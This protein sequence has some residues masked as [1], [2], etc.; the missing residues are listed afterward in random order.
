MNECVA[1]VLKKSEY[2]DEE[3][4]RYDREKV[5]SLKKR[6]YPFVVK[7]GHTYVYPKS[8]PIDELWILRGK[9]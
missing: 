9:K 8:M 2:P 7:E 5:D 6:G 1:M 4:W 3:S